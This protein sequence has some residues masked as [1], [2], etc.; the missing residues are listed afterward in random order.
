MGFIDFLTG[1]AGGDV[2]GYNKE[3]VEALRDVINST[4]QSTASVIVE[5]LTNYVVTP[6]S[7]AW[8]AEEAQEYFT[9]WSTEVVAKTGETIQKVFDGF[10]DNVQK[11]GEAWAE[12]TKGVAPVLAPIDDVTVTLSV[13]AIQATNEAGDRSLDEAAVDKVKS[14]LSACEE[15]I[16]TG[17]S[18]LAQNLDASTAFLGHNQ[19]QKIQE[20]FIR[21]AEAIHKIFEY[22]LNETDG[23]GAA[24][25]A[26]K[27]KYADSATNVATS[28]E[29][30]EVEITQGN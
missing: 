3:A 2:S 11:T 5:E 23:L 16:K 9:T 4:A 14:S 20:C 19:G 15:A 13:D 1:G 30:A 17:L 24:L 21:V 28:F 22:V 29:N 8:Y 26:Y 6:M 27:T 12:A 18:G 10:R 25:E 7:T